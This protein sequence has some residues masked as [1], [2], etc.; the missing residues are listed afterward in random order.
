MGIELASGLSLATLAPMKVFLAY[1]TWLAMAGVLTAGIVMAVYGSPWL[2]A[3][4][5]IGFVLAF[6]KLGCLPGH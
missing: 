3:L 5:A 4:G 6:A 1:F 2:L